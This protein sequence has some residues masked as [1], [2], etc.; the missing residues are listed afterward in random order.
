[1]EIHPF[2]LTSP[3][4]KTC[5]PFQSTR[6]NV[7]KSALRPWRHDVPRKVCRK[8]QRYWTKVSCGLKGGWMLVQGGHLGD[9]GRPDSWPHWIEHG[10]LGHFFDSLVNK[11]G[12]YIWV[13]YIYLE[14]NWPLFLKGPGP[15]QNKALFF[16]QNSRGPIWGS[17]QLLSRVK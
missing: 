14:P 11:M 3:A 2:S 4:K 17:R 10:K 7:N 5:Q 16:N 13:I 8:P 6:S 12:L 1:M 9:L 15:L